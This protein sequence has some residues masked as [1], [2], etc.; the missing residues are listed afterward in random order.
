[1][2]ARSLLCLLLGGLLAY[3]EDSLPPLRDGKVLQNLTELWDDYD[4]RKEPLAD[5]TLKE[6]E[7]DGIVC[8]V[9]RYQV[10]VFKGQPVRV[11]AF[12][13]FPKGALGL[14]ALLHIHGGGQSASLAAVVTDAKHG[15]ASLSLN[16]GGNKMTLADGSTYDGPNTDWGAL[17]AT[18]PPQRNKVNHF[19]GGT[20]PDAF[21]LDAVDSPRN[22]NW[23]LVTLAARRG[24]TYLERRPEAN[25]ERLGVYGHSMG[26]RLTVQLTGIDRRVKAAAPSCGGSGDLLATP[27]E[28][29]G[30]QRSKATPLALACTSENPYIARL[31]VPI[32]WISPTNDFHAQMDNMAW[33]WRNVP[34]RLLRLSISP[35]LNHRHDD[36]SA[37]AQHMWFEHHLVGRGGLVPEQP[38]ISIE[39][40]RV[41]RV[42]V[43]PEALKPNVDVRVYVTQDTHALSRFWRRVPVRREGAAFA[44]IVPLT[45]L[46]RPLFA[47]ANVSYATAEEY[48]HIATTPGVANSPTYQF[49]TREAWVTAEKLRASGAIALDQPERLVSTDSA[50][51]A[52]WYLLNRGHAALWSLHT[53]KIKDPKWRG[54]D[55]AKLAFRVAAR[56]ED[57]LA[58]RLTLNEWGAFGPGP[59]TEYAAH[60]ALKPVDGWA[61]VEVSTADFAPLNGAKT[62]LKD[63]STLTELTLTPVVPAELKDKGLSNGQAWSKGTEPR[64]QDLRWIGG[65]Y[66]GV[67]TAPAELSEADRTKTFND[68]IKQSLERE[69]QDARK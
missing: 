40:G 45:D 39:A 27:D 20:A 50:G 6:W 9:V 34:D 61:D 16:W 62:P 41:T 3:A 37:L 25:R 59:K 12:Y 64:I 8:R 48:G 38:A 33:N 58:V 52:D 54:P 35:H 57:V 24:L 26:G 13:A 21:T 30:G 65:T 4:P 66:L 18:H 67:R 10:G 29:P 19:A 28:M 44:A 31:N 63:W 43:T 42:V 46:S 68:S 11:A 23:F 53:R 2:S 22:D 51:L 1:M 17:D 49:S 55:G 36:A 47:F 32:L 56:T 15:Y 7:K 69:K 5:E 60:V 14:P